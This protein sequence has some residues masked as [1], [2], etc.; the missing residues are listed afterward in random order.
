MIGTLLN[1]LALLM[2]GG[3]ALATRKEVSTSHQNIL[4]VLL[5]LALLVAGLVRLWQ[6]LDF[7]WT[8][9]LLQMLILLAAM[10]LGRILGRGLGMQRGVNHLGKYAQR[11]YT[12]A[13]PGQ[14]GP[15]NQGFLTCTILFC[16]FPIAVTGAVLDG[17]V[18]DFS[19]L[20]VKSVMDGLAIMTF[21]RVFGWTVL[22]TVFPV[23]ALQGTI[24]LLCGAFAFYAEGPLLIHA[25]T[26]VAAVMTISI[27]LL[28]LEARSVPIA[29]YLPAYIL[30]PALTWV[31]LS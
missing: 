7:P 18:G 27:G 29:D 8:R 20:L 16:N 25:L 22:L 23:V 3:V 9:C 15:S 26:A 31:V 28:I 30:A 2:G 13:A 14:N 4:K 24:A 11:L 17:S 10:N 1:A 6:S 21:A 12:K 19:L 5:G